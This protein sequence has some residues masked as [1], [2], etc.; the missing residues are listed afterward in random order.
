VF[1]HPVEIL[2]FADRER[3]LDRIDRRNRR[4]NRR[5][6]NEIADLRLCGSGKPIDGRSDSSKTNVQ[7]RICNRSLRRIDRALAKARGE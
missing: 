5:R 4:Q 3:D 1:A 7:L 6:R 2:L